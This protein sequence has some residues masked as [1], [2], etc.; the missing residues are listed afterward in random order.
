MKRGCLYR[1][2]GDAAPWGKPARRFHLSKSPHYQMNTTKNPFLSTAPS[3][4]VVFH[5]VHPIYCH[6]TK[7]IAYVNFVRC[8]CG[9]LEPCSLC[10]KARFMSSMV[11]TSYAGFTS[12]K[13]LS[14]KRAKLRTR[15]CNAARARRSGLCRVR[16]L[17]CVII[18]CTY[19][20]PNTHPHQTN[21]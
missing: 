20:H 2:S 9:L 18:M 3:K 7:S 19:I 14:P 6:L 1:S 4:T 10:L 17:C 12:L 21:F 15:V 16:R 11:S 13:S 5:W 8:F